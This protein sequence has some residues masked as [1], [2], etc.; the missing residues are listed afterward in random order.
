MKILY[1]VQ[2]VGGIDLRYDIGDTVPV[3]YSLLG[4][5]QLNHDISYVTLAGREVRGFDDITSLSD[6]WAAPLGISQ[7]RSFKFLESASRRLQ[8]EIGLPYYALFDSFRFYEA[9]IRCLP[10]FDLCHEHNGLFCTGAALACRRLNKPYVLT[11]SADPIL[12]NR[13]V[14]TPLK[15]IHAIAARASARFTYQ[16]ADRVLCVSEPAKKQLVNT[17]NVDPNKITVMANGVDIDLFRPYPDD[18]QIRDEYGLGDSKIVSFVGGFQEWHGIDNLIDSFVKVKA[19]TPKVKILLVGDGPGRP[20]IDNKIS[21]MGLQSEVI[22][23]GNVPQARIPA[24]LGVVDIAVIPYPKFDNELWFSPLK[25]YEYMACGKAIVASKSGQ[26]ADVLNH[27]VD[28]LL[29]EPGEIDELAMEITKL[30]NNAPLRAK[31]GKQARA[32]AV[33]EH[34]WAKYFKRLE[35][36]YQSVL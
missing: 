28:G 22:I 10:N 17:W 1:A 5:R 26:I 23:T 18:N 7:T 13:I 8:R 9:L 20:S 25:L 6:Y 2:N 29:V 35:N 4:L 36:V 24:I 31:L 21:E 30:L 3:K 15:G 33:M 34:S 16:L 14:G 27:G 11:F 19:V 12:E 32:K